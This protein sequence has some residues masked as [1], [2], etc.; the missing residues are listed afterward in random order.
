MPTMSFQGDHLSEETLASIGAK[1]QPVS[2]QEENL[3]YI[4]KSY[5]TNPTNH[6]SKAIEINGAVDENALSVSVSKI[7]SL[8]PNLRSFYQ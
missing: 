4:I 1:K 5:P 3:A 2:Y 7:V 8:N 6:L